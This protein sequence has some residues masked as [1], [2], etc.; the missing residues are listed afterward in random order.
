VPQILSGLRIPQRAVSK[1]HNDNGVV[2]ISAALCR[3]FGIL[4]SQVL[5]PFEF[6]LS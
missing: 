4:E 3:I 5:S 1:P 6:L 2:S